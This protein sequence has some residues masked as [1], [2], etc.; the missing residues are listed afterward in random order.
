MTDD[1]RTGR[2]ARLDRLANTLDT[3]FRMPVLGIPI[4]W[5]SILGLIPG[6]GDL[7]TLGPGAWI[8]VEGYRMGAR[9]RVRTRH[10]CCPSA[11]HRGSTRFSHTVEHADRHYAA[12]RHLNVH[13][14]L[15]VQYM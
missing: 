14:V 2:L 5:D 13:K 6:V 15:A 11:S 7:I 4:G 12:R 1:N 9:K 10:S 8:V 3:K